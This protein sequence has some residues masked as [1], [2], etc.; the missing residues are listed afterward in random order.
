MGAQA[1]SGSSLT[2]YH[3]KPTTHRQ[4]L[5]A[6]AALAAGVPQWGS[7]W[8]MQLAARA[9]GLPTERNP[10]GREV[11]LARSVRP[12]PAG[13]R[14]PMFAGGAGER[15]GAFDAL[16]MHSDHVMPPSAW[17]ALGEGVSATVLAGNTWSP[18]QALE[19][20]FERSG[21]VFWGTP[22]ASP[23]NVHTAPRTM[24]VS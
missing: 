2:V 24:H 5:L 10:L 15:G 23:L 4:L 12:T 1:W 17:G 18:V 13:Q 11:G 6:S 20:K 19:V 7:C 8:G 14:H 22:P 21:G 9:A 3:E 16:C